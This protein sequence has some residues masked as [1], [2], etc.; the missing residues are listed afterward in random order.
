MGSESLDQFVEQMKQYKKKP[1][2]MKYLEKLKKSQKGSKKQALSVTKQIGTKRLIVSKL[3]SE[4]K[5]FP[6]SVKARD[7]VKALTEL[8]HPNK[9]QL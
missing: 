1:I 6:K 8:V 4:Q 2:S 5:Q 3:I 7:S 9:P